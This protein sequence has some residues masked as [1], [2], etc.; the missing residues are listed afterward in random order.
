MPRPPAPRLDN[1]RVLIVDDDATF[2]AL[3]RTTLA[4]HEHV[5][6]V[7]VAR[8]GVEAIELAETLAPT[9]VVMDMTMPRMGGIE[10]AERL[11]RLPRPPRVVMITGSDSPTADRRAFAAGASAYLRKSGD[12]PAMIDM[13]VGM[14][15]VTAPA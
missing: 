8:D 10:A 4:S 2:A 9:L 3:L 7:G 15:S 13:V 1:I 11:A 6:V 14:S 5:E 12:L